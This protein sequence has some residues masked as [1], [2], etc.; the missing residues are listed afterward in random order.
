[1]W[2]TRKCPRTLTIF[3]LDSHTT[4]CLAGGVFAF[5]DQAA[6]WRRP[7]VT[8][9]TPGQLL[10]HFESAFQFQTLCDKF[11]CS[12][13]MSAV[14]LWRWVKYSEL[15]RCWHPRHTRRTILCS[16]TMPQAV[17]NR[18]GTICS[19]RLSVETL[20]LKAVWNNVS[21]CVHRSW[22]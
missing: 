22:F 14:V 18:V 6:Y 5:A 3:F 13:S 16:A 8:P 4:M 10:E 7:T 17:L 21:L 19:S 2:C 15:L 1:M 11:I 20:P 9:G 12:S